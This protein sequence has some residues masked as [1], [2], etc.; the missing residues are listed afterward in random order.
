MLGRGL[1]RCLAHGIDRDLAFRPVPSGRS[2]VMRETETGDGLEIVRVGAALGAEVCGVDLS[3]P[4]RK[5]TRQ[6]LLHA[7]TEHLV[8]LFRDQRLSEQQQIAATRSLG[9]IHVSAAKTYYAHAGVREPFAASHPE[10]SV[11]HNL[12]PDGKPAGATAGLGAGEVPWHSDNSYVEAPPAGSMLYAQTV[13]P[14]GGD[15]C[16]SNQYAACESLPAVIRDRIDGRTAV[17]D[18][19]RDGSG[20]LRPGLTLPTTPAQVPGPHHPLV[21][22]HPITGRKALFLGRRRAYPSQYIDGM[23]EEESEALLDLLW[24]H[25]CRPQFVWCHKWR[26]GDVLLW[27]NRCTM[28]RRAAFPASFARVMHRTMMRGEVPE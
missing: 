22:T 5:K 12:G 20:A 11:V 6:R 25:S 16:F 24:K 14:E 21:R 28:H 10:I 17:H 13:P 19:S 3:R 15:T 4:L 23:P 2:H 27:D 9:E 7:W 18:A 1:G 8:L 26:R